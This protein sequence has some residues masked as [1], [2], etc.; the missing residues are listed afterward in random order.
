[1][2]SNVVRTWIGRRQPG[3]DRMPSASLVRES[4]SSNSGIKFQSSSLGWGSFFDFC[5]ASQLWLICAK[6]QQQGSFSLV[7]RRNGRLSYNLPVSVSKSFSFLLSVKLTYHLHLHSPCVFL[8]RRFCLSTSVL[9]G[10]FFFSS[11]CCAHRADTAYI[12]Q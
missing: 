4:F 2:V 9:W 7:G 8:L 11:S 12:Y 3:D 10:G 5:L 1:M 6:P